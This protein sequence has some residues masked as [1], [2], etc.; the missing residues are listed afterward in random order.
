[1]LLGLNSHVHPPQ[2]IHLRIRPLLPS[3]R[4]RFILMGQVFING[5]KANNGAMVEVGD[6]VR[7]NGNDLAP[8]YPELMRASLKVYLFESQRVSFEGVDY[9]LRN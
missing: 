4:D 3:P 5:K 6:S 1:M 8:L 7:A 9:V 2:Q